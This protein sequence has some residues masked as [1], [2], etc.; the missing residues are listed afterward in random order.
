[1]YASCV[2]S[3]DHYV[4][5]EELRSYDCGVACMMLGLVP[6]MIY[7]VFFDRN[8]IT[9]TVLAILLLLLSLLVFGVAAFTGWRGIGRVINVLG[10][11]LTPLYVY[12]AYAIWDRSDVFDMPKMGESRDVYLPMPWDD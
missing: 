1:M 7:F 11:I 2:Q 9:I 5:E 6:L 4:E 3:D 12:F 8:L 10:C